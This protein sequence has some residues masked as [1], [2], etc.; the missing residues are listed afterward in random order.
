ML[1]ALVIITSASSKGFSGTNHL[2]YTTNFCVFVQKSLTYYSLSPHK[3][4]PWS[5]LRNNSISRVPG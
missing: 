2:N 1:D 5:E 4:T 3:P